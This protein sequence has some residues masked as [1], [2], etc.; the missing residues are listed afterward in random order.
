MQT[1]IAGAGAKSPGT[2]RRRL[3][4]GKVAFF[5]KGKNK[6]AFGVLIG[7]LDTNRMKMGSINHS[8]MDNGWNG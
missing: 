1:R 5:L 8:Q 2:I 7:M 4:P 6:R 3:L